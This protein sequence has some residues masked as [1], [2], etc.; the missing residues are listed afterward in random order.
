MEREEIKWR[1]GMGWIRWGM[2]K[3][4]GINKR[5]GGIR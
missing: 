5:G 4:G 2:I 3:W 1:Q